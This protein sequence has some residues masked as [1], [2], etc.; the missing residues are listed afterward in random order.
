MDWFEDET[1][2]SE[3]YPYMFPPERFAAANEQVDQ[4]VAL[5]ECAAGAV[6]DLGC[7]PGRHSVAFAQRGFAVTGVDRTTF[8]LNRARERAA[9]AGVTIEW[10]QEDMRR[11]V[12][13]AM[14]DLACNLFTSFGYFEDEADDL[15]VLRNVYASLKNDGMFVIEMMSKERLARAWQNALCTQS[16]DGSLM[17]QRPQVAADW[18]RV[19]NDWIL[20]RDGRAQSFHFEHTIYSGREIK[21]RLLDCGFS[22][23][24]LFGGL[25]GSPYDLDA[26][27]L[28]AIA[29]K[30]R[31]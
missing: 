25:N 5:T 8:L 15:Q 6:L 12:R 17:I 19:K 18:C 16:A 1:F 13:P 20:V 2:W 10:V 9:E 7:G 27:R 21:D 22:E 24:Q 11:F 23:V 3:L 29:S 30:T 28:V 31:R 4:V 26:T 14:F